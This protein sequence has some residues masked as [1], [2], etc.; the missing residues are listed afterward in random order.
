MKSPSI[1]R[2]TLTRTERTKE[3][4]KRRITRKSKPPSRM[5]TK[6]PSKSQK[7]GSAFW[8]GKE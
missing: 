5:R 7:T 4:I 3:S 2:L 1:E 6:T 8:F